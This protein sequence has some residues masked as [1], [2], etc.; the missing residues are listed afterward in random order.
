MDDST[1]I[2]TESETYSVWDS[3]W[4]IRIRPPLESGSNQIIVLLHGWTGDEK[5]MEVFSP[6]MPRTATLIFP[7]APIPAQPSGYGWLLHHPLDR[8][9][10]L[11]FLSVSKVL[12]QRIEGQVVDLGLNT[13]RI[14]LV[15]F[16]QGA[17]FSLAICSFFP[18]W[19][20]QAAILAG[21]MPEGMTEEF[22]QS[23]THKPFFI[24]HGTNDETV[25]VEQAHKIRQILEDYGALVTYCESNT[26]H[27][28]SSECI[29]KLA[30]FF[31]A[32]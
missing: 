20:D 16:S 18:T 14:S 3:G 7:R 27:K 8:P 26:G 25:P 13:H 4:T 12:L 31:H 19:I 2:Q 24:A 32:G 22:S 5:S 15:G 21:F 29:K 10:I 28:L 30:G 6:S 11:D 9:S 17:A 23:F 1:S